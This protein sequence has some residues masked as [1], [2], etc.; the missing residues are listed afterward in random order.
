QNAKEVAAAYDAI[1][2]RAEQ[3]RP[4]AEIEGITVQPMLAKPLARELIVGAKR[5]PVFGPVILAG[6]GGITAE[7]YHDRALQLPPLN[8]RL[9]RRMLQ[10]LKIYPLLSGFRGRRGVDVDAV[11]DVLL[12][13]A[14]LVLECPQI[15]ELD[16]N[17]LLVHE[18]GAIAVD[19]RIVVG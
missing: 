10:S 12:R 14:T 8:K 16:I 9:A 13:V 4:D 19:A 1:I 18:R 2:Q 7:L 11:V 17:P 3:Q 6:A 5:D 15:A